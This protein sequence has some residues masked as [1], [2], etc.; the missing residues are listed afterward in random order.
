MTKNSVYD[1]HDKAFSKVAGHVLMEDG[2]QVGTI[3]FK[4]PT[5]GAGRL[6]CYFHI[7]GLPMVRAYAGGYGYDKQSAAFESAAKAARVVKLESWQDNSKGEYNGFFK[8]ANH[9]AEI[10]TGGDDWKHALRK[11]GYTVLTAI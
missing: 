5:D 3:A 10:D 11:A 4:F 8:I 7:H 2:E 1:H 6:W 9:I